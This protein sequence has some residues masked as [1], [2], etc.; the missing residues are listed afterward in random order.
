M[1]SLAGGSPALRSIWLAAW[2][3]GGLLALWIGAGLV[4]GVIGPF[5]S[6]IGM[7]LPVRLVHF[8]GNVV[9]I[10]LLVMAMTVL[11]RR[12]LFGG[13]L[14]FW[15]MLAI[16][17]VAALPGALI[18]ELQMRF[19]TPDVLRHVNRGELVFQ[20]LSLNLIL[21]TV[22]WVIRERLQPTMQP[23]PAPAGILPEPVIARAAVGEEQVDALTAKLP[24]ALRRARLI[25]LSAEDHYLKVHTDRGEA[26]ILMGLSQAAAA[27]G[28]R[29]GVRIHRSHWVAFDALP[30]DGYKRS[31]GALH[32]DGGLTLPVS[33]TGRRLLAAGRPVA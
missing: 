4:L 1:T 7:S 26:L 20:T 29:R 22:V 32:L 15:A 14:P 8:V 28:P 27:L 12:F 24:V 31:A 9:S 13:A 19:W 25:A 11:A 16:A 33:R 3:R 10:S 6:Y 17:V 23:I 21:G 18:V 2:S 30:A 5:G